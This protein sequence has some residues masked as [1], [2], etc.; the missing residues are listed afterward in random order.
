MINNFEDYT[1]ELTE[2]ER[3]FILPVL[4]KVLRAR[5]SKESIITNPEMVDKLDSKLGL[6]TSEPRIRK[7]ISV[8]RKTGLIVGLIGTSRGYYT[9]NNPTE[10]QKHIDSLHQRRNS[11][12]QLIDQMDYHLRMVNNNQVTNEVKSEV[13]KPTQTNLKL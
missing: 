3:D 4:V 9:T 8:I 6:K 13:K 2:N 1:H 5:T 10:I 11:I 12:D 7:I